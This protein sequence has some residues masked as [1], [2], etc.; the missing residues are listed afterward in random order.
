MK[1]VGETARHRT[2]YLED[3]PV[4]GRIY[5]SSEMPEVPVW[6]TS[7]FNIETLKTIL[8]IEQEQLLADRLISSVE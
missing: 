2:I 1:K 5:W 6:D 7:L 8:R 4:S 3:N